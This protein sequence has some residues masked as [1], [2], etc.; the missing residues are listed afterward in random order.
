MYSFKNPFIV[1]FKEENHDGSVAPGAENSTEE[2]FHQ[3][4]TPKEE[5]AKKT[6]SEVASKQDLF[7]K[8]KNLFK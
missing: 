4:N 3:E 1:F 7:T 8:L 2:S 6:Q 5:G